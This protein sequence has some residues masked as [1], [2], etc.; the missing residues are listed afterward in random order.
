MFSFLVKILKFSLALLFIMSFVFSGL[1]SVFNFPLKVQ[2]AQA[3]VA[4]GDGK[5]IYG[6]GTV[7]DPRTRSWTGTFDV[8]GNTIVA[9]ATIRH[10]IIKASP[11]RDEMIVGIQTTGGALYIQR[12]NGT[13]WSNEWNV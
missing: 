13:S 7:T 10:T 4:T 9:A 8:E 6:E 5:V 3:D 12:W 1:P 11:T 2:E